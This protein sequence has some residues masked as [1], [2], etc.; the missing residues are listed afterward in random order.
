V[1]LSSVLAPIV[2]CETA[3]FPIDSV[4]THPVTSAITRAPSVPH[5]RLLDQNFRLDRKTQAPCHPVASNF[6]RMPATHHPPHY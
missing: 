4:I 1:L 3:P 5:R 2:R 6:A